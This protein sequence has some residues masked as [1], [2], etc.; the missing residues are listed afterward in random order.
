MS[1]QST[2]LI[3]VGAVL[4]LLVFIIFGSDPKVNEPPPKSDQ[5]ATEVSNK[6]EIP[7]EQ[8]TQFRQLRDEGIRHIGWVAGNTRK[9]PLWSQT[10]PQV[11][12][13]GR[14]YNALVRTK[15]PGTDDDTEAI[16]NVDLYRKNQLEGE[17]AAY[18]IDENVL[19]LERANQIIEEMTSLMSTMASPQSRRS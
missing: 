3:A 18:N 10:S 8:L 15:V 16:G 9:T 13:G 6:V 14:Y 4:A 7:T 2:L 17:G 12:E 11:G 19:R 1:D 5:P